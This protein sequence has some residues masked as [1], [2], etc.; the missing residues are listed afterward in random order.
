MTEEPG[1]FRPALPARPR[2]GPGVCACAVALIGLV[3]LAL[4]GVLFLFG[5][6]R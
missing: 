2:I 5:F 6:H 4:F 1:P 3:A